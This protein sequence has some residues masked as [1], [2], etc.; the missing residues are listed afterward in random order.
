MLVLTFFTPLLASACASTP[1]LKTGIPAQV[2][3]SDP[4]PAATAGIPIQVG[5]G[6]DMKL[7]KLLDEFSRVTE[8]A[9]LIGPETKAI[10]QRSST[11]LNRSIEIPA[12]E[13]YPV[14]ETILSRNGFVLTLVHD[15]EPRLA[16]VFAMSQGGS[17]LRNWAIPVSAKDIALY[18]RHPAFLVTT[19]IDLPHIDVRTLSNSMRT[20]FTD[21]NTQQIIP[22]GNSNSLILT[23]CGGTVASIV[24]ML[25]EVERVAERDAAQAEK[26]RASEDQRPSPPSPQPQAK[27]KEEKP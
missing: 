26:R 5:P 17:D 21:A 18:A 24:R 13:V 14:V 3:S 7:E 23:G 25:Q 4:F 8:M 20:M 19:V 27:E 6:E 12:G 9:F 1:L 2:A 16:S 22:A 15:R 11:G 10:L